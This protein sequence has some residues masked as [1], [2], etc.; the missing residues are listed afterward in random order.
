MTK[1]SVICIIFVLLVLLSSVHAAVDNIYEYL[2]RVDNNYYVIVGLEGSS[3]DSFAATDIV[4][5]LKKNFNVDVQIGA[6]GMMSPNVNKILI[7]HPCDNS[8]IKLSCEDWPYSNGEAII[9]MIDNALIV[10]GS[11]PDDTRRAAKVLANFKAFPILKKSKEI[12]ITGEG[13][14]LKDLHAGNIS[15][16][17]ELV[18]GN[19]VCEPGERSTCQIDCNQ[20]SCFDLCAGEGFVNA[21]CREQKS[22]PNVLSCLGNETDQGPGYCAAG[23]IC[24]CEPPPA[25]Q[26][27]EQQPQQE[28]EQP[29]LNVIALIWNWLKEIFSAVF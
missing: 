6:E 16:P 13:L 26:P 2:K 29:K 1:K 22:N 12:L 25:A 17:G 23:K 10:A 11:T 14:E 19:G 5:S 21:Y 15:K 4:V 3:S 8:L 20:T 9:K 24:C 28:Q 7:G 18:C 27:T